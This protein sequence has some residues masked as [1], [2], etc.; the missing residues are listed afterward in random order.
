M[1]YV[2]GFGW[3]PLFIDPLDYV[4]K[5]KS[6]LVGMSQALTEHILAIIPFCKEWETGEK[7][8]KGIK[9]DLLAEA[10]CFLGAVGDKDASLKTFKKLKKTI[11]TLKARSSTYLRKN[12]DALSKQDE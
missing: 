9:S 11:E 6:D 2:C 4:P 10:K 1:K 5:D 3:F 8:F 12:F 7:D